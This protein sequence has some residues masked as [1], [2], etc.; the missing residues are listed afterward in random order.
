[1]AKDYDLEDMTLGWFIGD[2]EPHALKSSHFEVAVKRYTKG[3][4]EQ[5][6]HHKIATELTLI[7]EGTVIMCEQ[8]LSKGSIIRLEP[9]E[10]TSFVA[11]TDAI[12]VVVKTPSV[13]FDKY[14]DE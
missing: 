3:E 11:L 7:V 1:M 12:T 4:T 2:F 10:S 5:K 8:E 14:L 9:G 13:S 6:H